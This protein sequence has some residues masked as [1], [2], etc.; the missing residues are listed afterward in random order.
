MP[1]PAE[2]SK[3]A[4]SSTDRYPRPHRSCWKSGARRRGLRDVLSMIS[5]ESGDTA[6]LTKRTESSSQVHLAPQSGYVS[7]FRSPNWTVIEPVGGHCFQSDPCELLA[8]VHG[9]HPVRTR[10]ELAKGPR[11]FR[12]RRHA[13]ANPRIVLPFATDPY[14]SRGGTVDAGVL[15]RRLHYLPN[16]VDDCRWLREMDVVVRAWHWRATCPTAKKLPSLAAAS[17]AIL[18]CRPMARPGK[19]PC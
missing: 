2:W 8:G 5:P 18:V 12:L 7:N 16:H 6:P 1:L 11:N 14:L 9:G 4:G 19:G 10:L 13:A 3:T 17:A 15:P